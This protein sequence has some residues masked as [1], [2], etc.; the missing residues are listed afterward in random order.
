[1]VFPCFVNNA[2]FHFYLFIEMSF[3]EN[4]RFGIKYQGLIYIKNLI[5]IQT[6]R[7]YIHFELFIIFFY[8]IIFVLLT[9][10]LFKITMIKVQIW[11]AELPLSTPK[12]Y[13][14]ISLCSETSIQTQH[15]YASDSSVGA[16]YLASFILDQSKNHHFNTDIN[17]NDDSQSFE[18]PRKFFHR[19]TSFGEKPT[20]RPHQIHLTFFQLEDSIFDFR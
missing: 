7:Y 1:M 8:L 19:S 5:F 11:S 14:F 15:T 10:V 4:F 9:F 16:H 12:H 6:S 18:T 13:F 3:F 17:D 20:R 2:N